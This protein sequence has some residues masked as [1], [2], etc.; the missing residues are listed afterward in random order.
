M[1]IFLQV[2]AGLRV[3]YSLNCYLHPYGIL[4]ASNPQVQ[5]N[6]PAGLF[7]GFLWV[8]SVYPN[9]CYPLDSPEQQPEEVEGEESYVDKEQ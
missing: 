3:F 2:S 9:P 7:T 4:G 1:V 5:G 8:P 6:L